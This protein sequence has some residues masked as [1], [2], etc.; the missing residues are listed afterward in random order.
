MESLA[1]SR[2]HSIDENDLR[3]VY[4]EVEFAGH[5][6]GMRTLFPWEE[7]MAA[8][9][10]KE[11]TDT[12][13]AP[14]MWMSAVVGLALEHVDGNPEFCPR[15]SPSDEVYAKQRLRWTSQTWTFPFLERL[16][17]EYADMQREL[18]DRI[19]RVE[20]LSMSGTPQPAPSR[21]SLTDLATSA[22]LTGTEPLA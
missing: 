17:R 14:D 6:F 19:E 11:F 20:N 8:I 3:N 10:V 5:T 13:K 18:L 15:S 9:A 21:A 12:L 4:R 7:G 2:E 1:Q 16:Y 22:A